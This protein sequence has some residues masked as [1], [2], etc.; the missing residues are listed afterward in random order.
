[1]WKIEYRSISYISYRWV[2]WKIG[3]FFFK[4]EALNVMCD[5]YKLPNGSIKETSPGIYMIKGNDAFEFRIVLDENCNN[6]S[7]GLNVENQIL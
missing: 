4:E 3:T 2:Q 1:M 5:K 7:I 6:W